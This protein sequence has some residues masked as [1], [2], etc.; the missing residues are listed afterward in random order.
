MKRYNSHTMALWSNTT[1]S[2]LERDWEESS[3]K[4]AAKSSMKHQSECGAI[5]RPDR[6]ITPGATTTICGIERNLK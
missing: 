1:F 2:T 5:Q 3:R 6:A 4:K